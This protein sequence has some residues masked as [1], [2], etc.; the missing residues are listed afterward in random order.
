MI[1]EFLRRGDHA[2]TTTVLVLERRDIAMQS[3]ALESTV[4][5]WL[6]SVREGG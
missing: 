3:I 2:C 1:L 4:I 6:W 5:E